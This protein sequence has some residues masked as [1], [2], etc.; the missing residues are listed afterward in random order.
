MPA[1][2]L[3]LGLPYRSTGGAAA[4]PPGPPGDPTGFT[5]TAGNQLITITWDALPEADTFEILYGLTNN[6]S[7]AT[8]LGSGLTGT[9]FTFDSGE[10]IQAGE[11]YYFW[12]QATN[13]FGTSGYAGSVTARSFATIGNLIT[14]PLTTPT[15][16]WVLSTLF[17]GAGGN[18]PSGCAVAFSGGTEIGVSLGDGTWY[19]ANNDELFDPSISGAFTFDNQTGDSVTIWNGEP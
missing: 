7:F 10:S 14:L 12:I 15:G 4:A 17:F 2:G 6:L 3:S 18:L 19:D 1:L 13:G 16:S 5:A 11:K 9:S 8:T